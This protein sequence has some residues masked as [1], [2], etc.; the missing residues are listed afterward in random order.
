[1]NELRSHRVVYMLKPEPA[2]PIKKPKNQAWD[3]PPNWIELR[4]QPSSSMFAAPVF[5]MIRGY[6]LV[7]DNNLGWIFRDLT[8]NRIHN[9]RRIPPYDEETPLGKWERGIPGEGPLPKV[10]GCLN[11]FE[12]SY[13][14][15][16]PTPKS[17]KRVK[18]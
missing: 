1:M 14:K 15:P 10:D 5:E 2:E 7:R 9:F 6:S 16:E 18:E 8:H 17:A 13:T 4:K 11:T 12:I 3:N